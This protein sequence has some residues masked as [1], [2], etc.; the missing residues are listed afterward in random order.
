MIYL[1]LPAGLLLPTLSGWLLLRL[2]EGNSPVLF[3]LERWVAGGVLG[4]TGTMFVTFLCTL[5]GLPLTR[6]GF[7]F[8]Q[9]LLTA[10]LLGLF[11]WRRP[12]HPTPSPL[13]PTPS[14]SFP[15]WALLLTGLLGLWTLAKLVVGALLLTAT[16]PY[17]DD[18]FKNW[19]LRGKVFFL[20]EKLTLSFDPASTAAD[21]VSSYPPTV[22]MTKAWLAVLAGQWHEGLINS[23]HLLWYLAV[24][25][26][27][28]AALRRSVSLP[29]ALLGAYLFASLPL[30]L[31]HGITAYADIFL[32]VHLLLA[33][34]FLF[35]AFSSG[36][37]TARASFLRL[38]ALATALLV[39]TKNE[40]L[41]LHLPLLIILLLLGL[42]SLRRKGALTL[43]DLRRA[44]F[45]YGGCLAAV[46]L[47]WLLFKWTHGLTFGNAKGVIGLAIGW[48]PGVLRTVWINTFFE[49]SWLFF[50]VMFLTL[51]LLRWR[52][53]FSP[54]LAVVSL[55]CVASYCLQLSLYLFTSLSTEALRQTGYGRG[56]VQIAPLAVLLALLL[57][58]NA[59]TQ[60]GHRTEG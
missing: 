59:V 22:P 13:H 7:L 26:L 8:P 40:A 32:S 20:T 44:L 49:G 60:S 52:Q 12:S 57:L 4:L 35:H 48:Q 30:P 43:P 33:V 28:Y 14:S 11:L 24:L 19:N 27:L 31:L 58:C 36:N 16:P 34:S 23:I 55:F 9:I 41:L 1:W 5:L 21:G 54:P 25:F 2:L 45:W 51:L 6:L 3:R 42:V 29:W 47:P 38:G 39:F 10:V 56:L 18:V 50:P 17:F 46:L 37:P 15:L 53:A